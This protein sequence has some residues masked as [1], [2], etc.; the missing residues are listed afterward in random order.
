MSV[1]QKPLPQKSITSYLALL[2]ADSSPLNLPRTE[3]RQSLVDPE[4]GGVCG[5]SVG[6]R[7]IA[8]N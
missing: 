6:Y 7:N 2:E 1:I 5:L 4:D 3:Q 8:G